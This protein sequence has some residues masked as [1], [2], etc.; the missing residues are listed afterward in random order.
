VD[1]QTATRE[2]TLA[3]LFLNRWKDIPDK[4]LPPLWRAWKG[5]DFAD[6]DALE[7]A[8]LLFGSHRAKSVCFTEE[9]LAEAQRILMKYGIQDRSAFREKE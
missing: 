7:E 4:T 1:A 9:G 3:L 6:L 8:G 5:Y 2:L